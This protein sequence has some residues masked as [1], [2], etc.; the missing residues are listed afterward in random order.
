MVSGGPA[1]G[2]DNCAR[3]LL[4]AC[5][6]ARKLG[7]SAKAGCGATSS[8]ITCPV[9]GERVE[10]WKAASMLRLSYVCPSAGQRQG[11]AGAVMHQRN[12][13]PSCAIS[14][15]ASRMHAVGQHDSCR[16]CSQGPAACTCCHH[17]V[18]HHSLQQG[19]DTGAAQHGGHIKQGA[20]QVGGAA[21]EQ[22]PVQGE[23]SQPNPGSAGR[24][25]HKGWNSPETA[26]T[27]SA[28]PP[29]PASAPCCRFAGR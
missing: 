28:L 15:H 4:T 6:C 23:Q 16:A 11:R 10:R 29:Q 20:W 5:C 27:G 14:S 9:M 21:A 8:A 13:L 25:L 22:G 24:T 1:R 17:G 19:G 2:T 18:L 26:G 7:R 12:G 3:P